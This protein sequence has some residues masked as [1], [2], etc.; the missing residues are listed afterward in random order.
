M[1]P[2]M[3]GMGRSGTSMIANIVHQRGAYGGDPDQLSWGDEGDVRGPGELTSSQPVRE[4]HLQSGPVAN[5][6]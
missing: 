6:R 5:G 2:F 1:R 3:V 4:G